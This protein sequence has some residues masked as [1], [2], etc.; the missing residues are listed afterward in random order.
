MR[1]LG[2]DNCYRGRNQYTPATEMR[3]ELT[4]VEEE[5]VAHTASRGGGCDFKSMNIDSM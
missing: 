5:E 4:L 1:S 3:G 2:S